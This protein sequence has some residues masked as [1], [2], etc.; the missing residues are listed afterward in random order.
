MP[1]IAG[2]EHLGPETVPTEEGFRVFSGF[3]VRFCPFGHR[4]HSIA[5]AF[6]GIFQEI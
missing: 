3:F 5:R 6:F 1:Y 4:S 2:Q